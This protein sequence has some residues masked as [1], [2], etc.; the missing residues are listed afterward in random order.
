MDLK[1][2]MDA[3][4]NLVVIPVGAPPAKTHELVDMQTGAV[5]GKYISNSRALR[6][7]DRKDNEYGAVRYCVR[8]IPRGVA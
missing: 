2:L 4:P 1:T 8:R 6:A 5:V 7:G 3:C